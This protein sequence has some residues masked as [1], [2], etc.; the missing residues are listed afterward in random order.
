MSSVISIFAACAEPIEQFV[1]QVEA[2]LSIPFKRVTSS[3][4]TVFEARTEDSVITASRHDFVDDRDLNFEDYTYELQF[5]PLRDQHYAL[6]ERETFSYVK[7]A[8][9]KLK[10][11]LRSN[12][13]LVDD[14]QHKLDEYR[15]A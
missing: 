15:A 14:L 2:V 1:S 8:F 10:S 5:R 6:H 4:P 3:D 13:M 11:T 9:D 12:L 7:T